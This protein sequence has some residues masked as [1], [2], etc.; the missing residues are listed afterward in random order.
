MKLAARLDESEID[1]TKLKYMVFD[2]P[3][4]AGSYQDRYTSLGEA[5]HKCKKEF[6]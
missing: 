3:N 2:V 1:W 5:C 4:G 6:H